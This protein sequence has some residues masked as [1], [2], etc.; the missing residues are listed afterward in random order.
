LQE[1]S[2]VYQDARCDSRYKDHRNEDDERPDAH[3]TSIFSVEHE[4][5]RAC[6]E[7]IRRT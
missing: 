7:R 6:P 1:A 2:R 4:S 3:L 5:L